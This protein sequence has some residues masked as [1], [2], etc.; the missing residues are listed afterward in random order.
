MPS[1]AS[2]DRLAIYAPTQTPRA[3]QTRQCG[4]ARL[5]PSNILVE[6]SF[7]P[8]RLNANLTRVF[9]MIIPN[10]GN[11]QRRSHPGN[12]NHGRLLPSHPEPDVW[13]G[14][15]SVNVSAPLRW[16]RA[17]AHRGRGKEYQA[18]SGSRINISSFDQQP[19]SSQP[20]AI[21]WVH[22]HPDMT[23]P[24]FLLKW[25]P[26]QTFAQVPSARNCDIL[27]ACLMQLKSIITCAV[28]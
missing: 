3:Q 26:S 1:R 17:K 20:V 10:K 12:C 13:I 23:I 2:D 28:P 7:L 24:R 18:A 16:K 22:I 19:S 27:A 6:T 21:R 5:R 25:H 15:A 11:T 8:L 4:V 14:M 9:L